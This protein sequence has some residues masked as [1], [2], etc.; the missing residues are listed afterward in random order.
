MSSKVYDLI[1]EVSGVDFDSIKADDL[2]YDDL[3]ID[4]LQVAF[5]LSIL[6]PGEIEFMELNGFTSLRVQ[7]IE[8]LYSK[9]NPDQ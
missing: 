6:F 1:T 2:L 8:S 9:R 3:G 4:S 7:D 5:M